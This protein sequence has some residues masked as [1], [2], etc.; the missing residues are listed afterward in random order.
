MTPRYERLHR[1]LSLDYSLAHCSRARSLPLASPRCIRR[2]SGSCLSGPCFSWG[3]VLSVRGYGLA[4]QSTGT[5]LSA[6]PRGASSIGKGVRR[7][8]P[9][10]V[11]CFLTN[12]SL[13]DK[14]ITGLTPR[15]PKAKKIRM[16][17][18]RRLQWRKRIPCRVEG[19]GESR[20][21]LRPQDPEG[22]ERN[23]I[24]CCNNISHRF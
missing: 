5:H 24:A 16:K 2:V 9:D 12:W 23:R 15:G 14:I 4:F 19:V 10:R 11:F 1:S 22:D 6:A 8:A 21:A 13:V 3:R 18:S 7:A 20:A 17:A